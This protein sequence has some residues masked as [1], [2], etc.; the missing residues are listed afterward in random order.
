MLGLH[1]KSTSQFTQF[2][3]GT[4]SNL[5]VFSNIHP[6]LRKITHKQVTNWKSI[7]IFTV[8]G[9]TIYECNDHNTKNSIDVLMQSPQK[10]WAIRKLKDRLSYIIP[11][12]HILWSKTTSCLNQLESYE[13]ILNRTINYAI[14]RILLTYHWMDI[15]KTH[16]QDHPQESWSLVHSQ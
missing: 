8:W 12:G 16:H 5:F 11:F 14:V 7:S 1:R 4:V 13:C 10:I 15:G 3:Q 9:L 2:E 6:R